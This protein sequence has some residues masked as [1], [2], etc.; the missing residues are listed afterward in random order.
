MK[1]KT[2]YCKLRHEYAYLLAKI[3]NSE[4]KRNRRETTMAVLMLVAGDLL[5]M[6][7]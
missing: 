1:S 4:I 3:F 7:L 2:K 6:P 5:K